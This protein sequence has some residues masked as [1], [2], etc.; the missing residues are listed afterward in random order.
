MKKLILIGVIIYII[1][2]NQELSNKFIPIFNGFL[3]NLSEKLDEFKN[4]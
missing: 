3:K 4:K 2:N 1:L